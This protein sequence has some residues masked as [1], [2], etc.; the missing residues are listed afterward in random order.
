MPIPRARSLA[1]L[2]LASSPL[3]AAEPAPVMLDAKEGSLTYKVVHKLHEVAATC[4]SVEGKAAVQPD[5]SAKVQVRAKVACFDSGNAN[6]D[7][8]MHEVTHEALH[9][10]VTVKGTLEGLALPLA[11]KREAKLAATLDFNGVKQAL[12][13]PVTLTSEGARLRAKFSFP[14][15]LEAFQIERPELLFVKV[16]DAAVIEGEVLFEPAQTR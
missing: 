11:D 7:V 13:I 14:I 4:T 2:L 1:V 6:R 12:T 8:H 9:P 3:A 10:L 16:D 5:G 15:S